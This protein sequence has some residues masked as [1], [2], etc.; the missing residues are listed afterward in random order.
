MENVLFVL[1]IDKIAR[2]ILVFRIILYDLVTGTGI[3]YA[4]T[5]DKSANESHVYMI[6]PKNLASRYA[7][8]DEP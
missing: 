2:Q 3:Y 8:L 4:P 5:M 6:G 1:R 7:P